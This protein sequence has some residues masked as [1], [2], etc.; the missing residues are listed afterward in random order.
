MKEDGERGG[1][2]AP[3][4]TLQLDEGEWSASRNGRFTSGERA[5]DNYWIIGW[6]D[7]MVWTLRRR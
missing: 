3:F 1:I 7:A 4:S 6:V 2:A 5:P